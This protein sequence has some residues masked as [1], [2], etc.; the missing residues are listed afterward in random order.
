M[1]GNSFF[2]DSEN[3]DCAMGICLYCLGE[4]DLDNDDHVVYGAILKRGMGIS[5]HHS[6]TYYFHDHCYTETGIDEQIGET[7]QLIRDLSPY[8][9]GA[10]CP[11]C[12]NALR[13]TD[14]RKFWCDCCN[15]VFDYPRD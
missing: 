10:R 14:N 5:P 12:C 6:P 2:R 1:D 8:I 15:I 9:S 3:D 13:L 11:H 4:I 7:V